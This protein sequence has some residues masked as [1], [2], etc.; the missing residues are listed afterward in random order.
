VQPGQWYKPNY[1]LFVLEKLHNKFPI[2]GSDNLAMLVFNDSSLFRDQ[3]V[4]KMIGETVISQK[5]G[6][7]KKDKDLGFRHPTC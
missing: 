1:I 5:I 3:I 6:N 7:E 4:V 2:R